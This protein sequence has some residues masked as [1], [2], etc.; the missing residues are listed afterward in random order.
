LSAGCRGRGCEKGSCYGGLCGGGAMSS[1][2]VN[3]RDTKEEQRE[4]SPVD[5]E[6]LRSGEL[7]PAS[8]IAGPVGDGPTKAEIL[9]N[10]LE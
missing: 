6:A 5:Q 7:A 4:I 3:H 10:S 8:R 9:L 1:S 2:E